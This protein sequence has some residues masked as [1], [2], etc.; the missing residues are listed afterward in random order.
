MVVLAL[1]TVFPPDT[2]CPITGL[3]AP[4]SPIGTSPFPTTEGMPA[5]NSESYAIRGSFA[6]L[7][8]QFHYLHSLYASEVQIQFLPP[9]S[10]VPSLLPHSIKT[11]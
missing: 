2:V 1:G 4:L 9:W 11:D 8:T 6:P 3:V 7:S 5:C 10:L